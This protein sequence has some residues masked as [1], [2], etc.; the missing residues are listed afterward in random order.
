MVFM[1]VCRNVYLRVCLRVRETKR[2]RREN[3]RK[4]REREQ[5]M[6]V[7]VYCQKHTGG[8]PHAV[9]V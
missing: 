7:C 5:T 8:P 3:E 1:D 2:G 6:C 9:G 4:Q